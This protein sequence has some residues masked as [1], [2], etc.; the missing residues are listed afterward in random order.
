MLALSDPPADRR[1]L[2]GHF[3]VHPTPK[4]GGWLI[5]AEIERSL[6]SRRRLG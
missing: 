4:L 5:Q 6:L 1:S 3:P 2:V